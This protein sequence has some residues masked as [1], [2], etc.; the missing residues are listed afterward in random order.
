MAGDA[1]TTLTFDTLTD[2]SGEMKACYKVDRPN[3]REYEKTKSRVVMIRAT[4]MNKFIRRH[5]MWSQFLAE[6]AGGKR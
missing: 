2:M 5:G 6:D 4:R 3:G 1:K